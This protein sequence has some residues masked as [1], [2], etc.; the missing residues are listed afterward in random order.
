MKTII[1]PYTKETLLKI[2]ENRS[3]DHDHIL[4]DKDVEIVNKA[5]EVL[6]RQCAGFQPGVILEI[7]DVDYKGNPILYKN[8]H[9]DRANAYGHPG[10]YMCE[11]PYVSFVYL[12]DLNTAYFSTSGGAWH[13]EKDI[14]DKKF[15]KIGTRLKRFKAWGHGGQCA[16]GA[17]YFDVPV[18]VYK[19]NKRGGNI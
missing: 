2:G 5:Y 13:F 12:T 7:H 14:S 17:V 9:F 1:K 6:K 19:Y 4:N 3:Y 18:N 15:T 8:G 16:N 10:V 11:E